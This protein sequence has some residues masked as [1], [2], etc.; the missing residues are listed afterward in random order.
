MLSCL[1]SYVAKLTDWVY[2]AYWLK[3]ALLSLEY[4]CARQQV[5]LEFVHFYM[6]TATGLRTFNTFGSKPSTL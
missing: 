3:A 6:V 4:V 1:I 2:P 5:Q